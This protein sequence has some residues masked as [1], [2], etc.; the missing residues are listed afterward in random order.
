MTTSGERP[1]TTA[2]ESRQEEASSGSTRMT[3]GIIVERRRTRSRWEPWSW[4]PVEALPGAPEGEPWRVLAEGDGWTRYHAGNL[5]LVMRKGVTGEYRLNLSQASPRLYVVL[6]RSGEA[7]IPWRPLL[8]TAAPDEAGSYLDGGEELVEGVPMPPAVQA[9]VQDFVTRHHVEKP[10]VK[11][12]R[13][14][15]LLVGGEP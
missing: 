2:G 15:R 11:R 14:R 1:V 4:L 13:S 12:K 3:M 10:F 9:W 6:R 8:V 5:P 7:A